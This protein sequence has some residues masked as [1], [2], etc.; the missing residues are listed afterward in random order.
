MPRTV[1]V[2]VLVAL[3]LGGGAGLWL[4]WSAGGQ[5]PPAK[6]VAIE[7]LD[8]YRTD[9]EDALFSVRPPESKPTGEAIEVRSVRTAGS[10]FKT[11]GSFRWVERAAGKFGTGHEKPSRAVRGTVEAVATVAAGGASGTTRTTVEGT[12]AYDDVEGHA[13]PVHRTAPFTLAFDDDPQG[14]AVRRSTLFQVPPD[15]KDA[16]AFLEACWTAG[17][18]LLGRSVRVGET[19]APGDGMDTEPMRR[20]AWFALHAIDP[21]KSSDIANPEGGVWV[22]AKQEV[23]GEE[24]LVVRVLAQHAQTIEVPSKTGSRAIGYG[25]GTV[26]TWR[27]ATSDGL[28]L[29]CD[30]VTRRA[31]RYVGGTDLDY[32]VQMLERADL[33]TIRLR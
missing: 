8:A 5:G 26:G 1:L 16:L 9:A 22:Q 13:S 15:L 4:L 3:L 10:S 12:L 33:T 30:V 7:S 17:P 14:G 28:V 6:P 19:V 2:L 32:T 21:E 29:G 31:V 20:A 18:P 11:T 24:A 25:A 23:G 27:L